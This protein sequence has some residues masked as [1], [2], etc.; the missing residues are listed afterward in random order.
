MFRKIEPYLTFLDH[1]EVG[2]KG[3]DLESKNTYVES[4]MGGLPKCCD[5]TGS[6]DRNHR[7]ALSFWNVCEPFTFSFDLTRVYYAGFEK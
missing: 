6:R 2:A 3:A 1:S 7:L 5:G 4:V